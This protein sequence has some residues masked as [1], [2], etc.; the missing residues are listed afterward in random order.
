MGY[1]GKIS[2]DDISLSRN[3]VKERS[4]LILGTRTED[5]FTRSPEIW[6]PILQK[7]KVWELDPAHF[8]NTIMLFIP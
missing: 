6:Y 5:N 8:L 3:Q 2:I 1:L 7:E 4:S